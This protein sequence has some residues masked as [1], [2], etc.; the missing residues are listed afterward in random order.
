MASTYVR[1]ADMTDE[2]ARALGR[3]HGHH[4]AHY[5]ACVSG[6]A[7]DTLRPEPYMP[8][9]LTYRARMFYRDGFSAGI[10]EYQIDDAKPALL[11]AE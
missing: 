11:G 7:F 4:A 6:E 5:A 8:P 10:D 3:R 9:G 2:Q 1:A